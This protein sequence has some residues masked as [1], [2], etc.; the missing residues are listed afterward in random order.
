MRPGEESNPERRGPFPSTCSRSHPSL[1]WTPV[2]LME[3]DAAEGVAALKEED[4]GPELEVHGSANLAQTLIHHGLVDEYPCGSSPSCS[5]R[6][7]ACS[8]TARSHL[9]AAHRLEDL[10]HRR[11]HGHLRAG[12]RRRHWLVLAGRSGSSTHFG[13]PGSMSEAMAIVPKLCRLDRNHHRSSWPDAPDPGR[14][15]WTHTG[16][17]ST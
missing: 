17:V 2:L 9:A 16:K 10:P 8:P 13:S 12:R 7:S 11:V 6:G 4:D 15:M 14:F 1:D 5:G 3:G